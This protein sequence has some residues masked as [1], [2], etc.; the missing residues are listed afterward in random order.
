MSCVAV[1][2][3]SGN[4]VSAFDVDY[5]AVGGDQRR[6]AAELSRD[7]Q[8]LALVRR[9]GQS[10]STPRQIEVYDLSGEL[11]SATVADPTSFEWLPDGRLA[12]SVSRS[13]YVTEPNRTDFSYRLDLPESLGDGF[14][15]Y[16]A[17]SPGGGR[18]AFSLVT[19]TTSVSVDGSLWVLDLESLNV[20][21]LSDHASRT[22]MVRSPRWSPDGDWIAVL[23]G[24]ADGSGVFTPGA[25]S[26][27]YLVPTAFPGERVYL[28]S[29]V[30]SE[31][32]PEVIRLRRFRTLD[33]DSVTSEFPDWDFHWLPE[34][35]AAQE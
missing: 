20:L 34:R 33:Q 17:V 31:R 12:Y 23:E 32:S 10:V 28:L 5:D 29:R 25:P 26:D 2:D 18:I 30:D 9:P 16:L 27:M 8:L 24:G 7:R 13:I 3:F 14:I 1:Q 4:V 19:D 11:L 22:P 35:G 15:D 6:L 21:R